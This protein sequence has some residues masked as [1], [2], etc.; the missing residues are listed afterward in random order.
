MSYKKI[1]NLLKELQDE[2]EKE[3]VSGICTL[4]KKGKVTT[5]LTGNLPDVAFCLAA[6]EKG[7][8]GELPIPTRILREA[9]LKVIEN[10]DS[11][12]EKESSFDRSKNDSND[13]QYIFDQI[14][15]GKE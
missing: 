1:Q 13:F 4:N 15:G 10:T 3:G 8:D 2:C 14:F 12:L 6:Q 7:F 9:G 5:M 11:E